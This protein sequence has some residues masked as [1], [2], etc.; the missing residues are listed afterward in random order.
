VT[1]KL[2]YVQAFNEAVRQEMQSDPDVFCAGEDIGALRLSVDLEDGGHEVRVSG[3]AEVDLAHAYNPVVGWDRSS[4]RLLPLA[5][6]VAG[7]FG[8]AN[9]DATA[10]AR[11]DEALCSLGADF[12]GGVLPFDAAGLVRVELPRVPGAV[13]GLQPWRQDRAHPVRVPTGT[14]RVALTLT[15]PE[16]L[17]P[18]WLPEPV[19]LENRAGSLVRTV[20]RD[21]STVEITEELRLSADWL[22]PGVWPELRA[23]LNAVERGRTLLLERGE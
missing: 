18:A 4:D 23:L 3:H 13:P 14:E 1:R 21:G 9:V 11:L 6:G 7:V 5:R 2:A 22:A 20:E 10:P 16:D 17:E 15:L 8:G 12:S 19:E